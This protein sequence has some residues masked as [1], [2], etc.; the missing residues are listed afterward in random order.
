[1]TFCHAFELGRG[2]QKPRGAPAGLP[3]PRD[4]RGAVVGTE[5]GTYQSGHDAF[6][7]L[8]PAGVP[9]AELDFAQPRPGAENVTPPAP[10]GLRPLFS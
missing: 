10:E 8:A 5:C 1:M 7:F 9:A 2:E 3:G 6:V 4:S